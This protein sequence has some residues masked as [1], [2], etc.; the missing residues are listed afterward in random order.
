MPIPRSLTYL[1]V[2]VALVGAF[3]DGLAYAQDGIDLRGRLDSSP[4]GT[5]LGNRPG[6]SIGRT[7]VSA[8]RRRDVLPTAR[9][10]KLI[11]PATLPDYPLQL[12][13]AKE[14]QSGLLG[15]PDGMCLA[16]AIDRMIRLN[17]DIA[18]ALSE[19]EQARADIT[20]AALRSNPQFFSD[21]QQV[22][23][24]VLAPYQV[25][26]NIAYPMDVSKKRLNRVNSAACVLRSVEWRYKN[27]V[28][29]QIDNLYTTFIDALA[30]R[31]TLIEYES[32][33]EP[34]YVRS[35]ET[36]ASPQDEAKS[37]LRDKQLALAILL[38]VRDPKSIKVKGLIYDRRSY[39]PGKDD[40]DPESKKALEELKRIACENRPDLNARRWDLERALADVNVVR[41]S[42]FDDVTFLLQPYTY[43]PMLPNHVGWAF[44]I[45]VP[46]PIYNRQQGNL[47]KAEQIVLQTR[48]QL[49][50]LEHSVSVEVEAAYN[51]VRD[52]FDDT[53]RFVRELAKHKSYDFPKAL[54][55]D[56]M[57]K[58]NLQ[59][60]QNYVIKL[61]QRDLER[62]RR[63]YY[64][65]IIRHRKSLLRINT[66]CGCIV[67]PF[68]E[69]TVAALPGS[70]P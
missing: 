63:N 28:R 34:P 27:F 30:A 35:D 45:T 7:P 62:Q 9:P 54:P 64:D 48:A 21:M 1:A 65:A 15:D 37:T 39:C 6:A 40:D 3:G 32:G 29:V 44:G 2:G 47:A 50:S 41:A 69:Q 4:D 12:S 20:T 22:P 26:V 53:T 60:L 58:G 5:L 10:D 8:Y 25:D 52:T 24:S 13:P 18:S 11:P 57:L 19:L 61:K 55:D 49:A 67:V 46:M 17:P 14:P 43:T 38:N 23:Y 36:Q 33:A 42:R 66:A 68:D 31:Q 51:D 70:T 59:H 16:E 56:E